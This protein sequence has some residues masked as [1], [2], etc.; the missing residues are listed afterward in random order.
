MMESQSKAEFLSQLSNMEMRNLYIQRTRK[1]KNP[2]TV[3]IGIV[4]ERGRLYAMI[5]YSRNPRGR[6]L[7][8]RRFK[9]LKWQV[10]EDG[11]YFAFFRK[12][13]EAR[14]FIKKVAEELVVNNLEDAFEQL[15]ELKIR[16]E[17]LGQK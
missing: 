17:N 6:W 1:S 7:A 9:N 8:K 14:Q 10:D 12:K 15:N 4:V 11:S 3:N 16:K 13:G 5:D 2:K